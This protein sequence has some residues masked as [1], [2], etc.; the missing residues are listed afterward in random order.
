MAPESVSEVPLTS[1]KSVYARVMALESVR[2]V[3]AAAWRVPLPEKV[4]VFVPSA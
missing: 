1:T 2:L 4:S 3:E